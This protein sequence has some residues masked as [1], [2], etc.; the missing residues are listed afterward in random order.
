MKKLEFVLSKRIKSN[1]PFSS[2][3]NVAWL[4]NPDDEITQELEMI[5]LA[6]PDLKKD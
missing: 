5:F 3:V 6:F 1:E 2:S 4:K